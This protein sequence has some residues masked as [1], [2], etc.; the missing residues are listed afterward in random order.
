MGCPVMKVASGCNRHWPNAARATHG[1]DRARADDHFVTYRA[2]RAGSRWPRVVLAVGIHE[3]QHVA[4]GVAC[5]ALDGRAVAQAVGMLHAACAVRGQTARCRR[6]CRRRRRALRPLDGGGAVPAAGARGWRL[7]ARRQ[8]DAE[9]LRTA[10]HAPAVSAVIGFLCRARTASIWRNNSG[11]P[12]PRVRRRG[13]SAA[14]R[15]PTRRPPLARSVRRRRC[16][17]L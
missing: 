10:A 9:R 2:V 5:A 7:V 17:R 6:Y 11:W 8:D 13:G 1:V 4:V 12:R 16:P 14:A 3:D 15:S